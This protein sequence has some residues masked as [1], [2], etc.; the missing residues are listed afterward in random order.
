MRAPRFVFFTSILFIVAVNSAN[1][2]DVQSRFW[3]AS[4]TGDTAAVRE[5]ANG[6]ARIDSLDTRTN[7]NGRRALNWAA[8]HN[9]VDAVKLL[10]ELKAPIEAENLTG[11]TALHHA[12]ENGSIDV[13][14]VLLAAGANPDHVNL[15]GK[16]PADTARE[17]GHSEVA[18]LLDA[19]VRKTS[20]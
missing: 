6:G 4:I 13:V 10:L 12:A 3:D 15:A 2:Q 5:A 11:F 18:A 20:K 7:R 19:A 1:A 17:Q 16:K 8:W 9:R 14:R